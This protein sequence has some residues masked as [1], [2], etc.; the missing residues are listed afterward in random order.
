MNS[1]PAPRG[2]WWLDAGQ[3]PRRCGHAP[4]A[5][6]LTR[7]WR[8]VELL[9]EVRDAARQ[10]RERV[11][12]SVADVTVGAERKGTS[13]TQKPHRDSLQMRC[14]N[15]CRATS[16]RQPT[17]ASTVRSGRLQCLARHAAVFV[18][19]LLGVFESPR[20]AALPLRGHD[21][22][23]L[24][25]HPYRRFGSRTNQVAHFFEDF[26]LRVDLLNNSPSV[27]M[28][29]VR[30]LIFSK[31]AIKDRSCA[32]MSS[33]RCGST[34]FAPVSPRVVPPSWWK[35]RRAGTIEEE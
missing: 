7:P 21:I 27:S 6:P 5:R 9:V 26:F 28:S 22:A 17:S 35:M 25:R 30:P 20:R 13:T 15:R 24:F 34:S 16:R 12:Q 1:L 33:T 4:D 11:V 23:N 14:R 29:N 3:A 10:C 19:K 2:G 18:P 31:R 8:V 32:V